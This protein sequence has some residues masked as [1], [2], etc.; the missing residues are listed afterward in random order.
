MSHRGVLVV[1]LAATALSSP[2][3]LAAV[4]STGVVTVAAATRAKININTADVNELMKL[5]GVGRDLAERIVQYR[6]ANGPFKKATDL[7]KVDGVG[8]SLWQKNRARIVV[9]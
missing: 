8:R 7:R 3:A 6:S 1:L 2:A 5:A 9:K 4:P